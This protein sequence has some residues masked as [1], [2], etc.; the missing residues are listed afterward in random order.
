MNE[1]TTKD[2]LERAY[3]NLL[4]RGWWGIGKDKAVFYARKNRIDCRCAGLHILDATI[5]LL[6]DG[7]MFTPRADA[8]M[9]DACQ[10][11]INVTSY[12]PKA[13]ALRS[14]PTWFSHVTRWNDTPN[15]HVATV[16]RAF[17]RAIKK[18]A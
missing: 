11:L 1:V 3:S 6:G 8:L 14:K 18:A 16:K 12:K 15:R 5:E 4:Q 17:V 10:A 13:Q 7:E 9:E 2:V